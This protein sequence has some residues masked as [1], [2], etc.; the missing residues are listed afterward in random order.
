MIHKAE[1][2][3]DFLKIYIASQVSTDKDIPCFNQADYKRFVKETGT[4]FIDE[5][6]PITT[7]WEKYSETGIA[8]DSF[9]IPVSNEDGTETVMTTYAI[10][11]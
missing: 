2:L 3:E 1:S 9:E 10:L 6:Y 7:K 11:V 4:P 8:E 5:R